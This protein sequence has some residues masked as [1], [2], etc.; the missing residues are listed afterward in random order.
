ME[1][2]EFADLLSPGALAA[3]DDSPAARRADLLTAVMHE[4]GNVLGYG[5]TWCYPNS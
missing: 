2:S 3:R 5:H 1:Y 4:M